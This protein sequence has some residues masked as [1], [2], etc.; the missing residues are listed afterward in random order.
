MHAFSQETGRE[1]GGCGGGGWWGG[2]LITFS[3]F[4][5]KFPMTTLSFLKILRYWS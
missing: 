5:T 3:S 4:M 2:A 1:Q